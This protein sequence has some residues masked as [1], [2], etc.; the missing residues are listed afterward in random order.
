[1]KAGMRAAQV[2][3]RR[4]ALIVGLAVGVTLLLLVPLFAMGS[5]ERAPLDPG[6]EVFELRDTIADRFSPSVFDVLFV[7]EARSGDVLT[8][9][10]LAE[11]GANLQELRESDARGELAAGEL[12]VQRYLL[13][14]TAPSSDQPL[15]GGLNFVDGVDL[16][17]GGELSLV[18][19]TDEDVKVAIH[20]L[21]A[22]PATSG[23]RELF[24]VDARREP[25]SVYGIDVDSWSSPALL[26]RIGV[27]N[28]KLGGGLP[29]IVVGGDSAVLDRERLQ[30][31]MQSLL[32]GEERSFRL[33]AIGVDANLQAQ[34][35][36]ERAG[37]F[38]LL[39][40]IAAL[41]MVGMTLRSYWGVALTGAGLGILM[42]WL[43]GGANLIGIQGGLVVDLIVPIAMVSLGVDFAIHALRRYREERG[44]GL[45][46]RVALRT[47]FAGVLGA[48]TLAMLS[49]AAAFLANVTSPIAAV[50]E[51]GLAT[52]I[53]VFTA[54]IVLGVAVPVVM[55]KVDELRRRQPPMAGHGVWRQVWPLLGGVFVAASSGTGVIVLVALDAVAGVLIIFASIVM[56]VGLPFS[57]LHWRAKQAH[58]A[59]FEP[60][61]PTMVPVSS[62]EMAWIETLVMGVGRN[63]MAVV[64]AA[65][66]ITAGAV[67]FAL[68]VDAGMDVREFFSHDSDLVVGL[69]KLDQHLPHHQREPALIL[70]EGDLTDVSALSAVQE[71][72]SQVA[73]HRHVL[74]DADGEVRFERDIFTVLSDLLASERALGDMRTVTG[75]DLGYASGDSLP[76]S[77][78]ALEAAF[79]YVVENGVISDEG[80][81]IHDPA[82][83]REVLAH[84]PGSGGGQ[85]IVISVPIVGTRAS[86][87]VRDAARDLEAS[88]AA[89]GRGACH[90][91]ITA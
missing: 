26:L 6:G 47:G 36:G 52:A 48:L 55:A 74:R 64:A 15:A 51:F 65:L 62:V 88:I 17:L 11:L 25:E 81:L 20:A 77:T 84:E 28:A 90:R 87:V 16:A 79:D 61:A 39:T 22:D 67:F 66:L 4:S 63:R 56:T 89:S 5:D 76:A 44:Q 38:I 10:V 54:F 72:R 21:L 73:D 41:A 1:M 27:D 9:A 23:F 24:A 83:V 70:V 13:E 80:M 14:V 53:A 3:E 31:N 59:G 46:P 35:D 29:E 33:W 32:R 58:K 82:D 57:W 30:R 71:A 2:I 42:I 37:P 12:P 49:G 7:V 91:S 8:A 60:T 75:V 86:E 85:A 43:K 69:D 40:V 19:A 78:A 68:R 18:E 50:A 45:L 34:D